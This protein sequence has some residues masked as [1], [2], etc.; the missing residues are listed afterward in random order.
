MNLTSIH[1]DSGLIPGFAQWVKV[2]HCCGCGVDRSCSSSLTPSLGT[3]IC[4]GCGPKK[5]KTKNKKPW[6]DFSSST[7][8]HSV[9][10]PACQS[11]DL[12][13]SLSS[14]N[15][16]FLLHFISE[17]IVTKI[18][19]DDEDSFPWRMLY[20]LETCHVWSFAFFQNK[21]GSVSTFSS[22]N[23]SL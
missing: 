16:A 6:W 14:Q 8:W 5:T 9:S 10:L 23:F 21:W 1:E 15:L 13:C 18:E 19:L 22:L 12:F 20:N 2:R 7:V 3:S 4:C 11:D 17:F